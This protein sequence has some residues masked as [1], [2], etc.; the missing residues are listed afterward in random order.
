MKRLALGMGRNKPVACPPCPFL[1]SD[2]LPSLLFSLAVAAGT[3][4]GRR[5]PS[6][7]WR[8]IQPTCATPPPTCHPSEHGSSA[9]SLGFLET[10]ELL[11][12]LRTF[13]RRG[14]N[15]RNSSQFQR[16]GTSF[17]CFIFLYLLWESQAPSGP[18]WAAPGLQPPASFDCHLFLFGFSDPF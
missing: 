11:L 16:V 15:Q 8:I 12:G 1:P 18:D 5:S 6:G 14:L 2:L 10:F 7:R 13:K 3:E 17:G 9:D 4:E